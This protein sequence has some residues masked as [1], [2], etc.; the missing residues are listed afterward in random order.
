M[1]VVPAIEPRARPSDRSGVVFDLQRA[2][3]R[4]GP[5]IRTT[6]FL[7]GC[8]LR[9]RWC[10]NPESQR[11]EPQT[12]KA[13]KHYGR[14]MRVGEIMDVVL[15]DRAYYE[16]SGGGLTISGGEPTAQYEFCRALLQAARTNGIHTCL[17]TS[18]HLEP[19][20]FRALAP[21]VDCFLFDFKAA[22]DAA[23]RALTGVSNKW[24]L[25]NLAWLG[26]T[27]AALRLRCPVV[28]GVNADDAYFAALKAWVP[29][30]KGLQAVDLLPYHAIGNAKYADVG[31]PLPELCTHVPDDVEK[32]RWKDALADLPVEVTVG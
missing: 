10:H 32:Q 16:S 6:V 11:F 24:I 23:H 27:G 2:A 25:E 14:T 30:L 20:R 7:K 12:G 18:G 13:G 29:R 1:S 17:D 4:D 22:D 26:E 28:P 9:C 19:E 31:M 21:W 3:L 8:P 15:R 5:G